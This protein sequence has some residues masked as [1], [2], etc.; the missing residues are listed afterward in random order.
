M[1]ELS[2]HL[3]EH[4][5]TDPSTLLKT[6]IDYPGEVFSE[7]PNR[8]TKRITI[9]DK[10]YFV[11]IHTGVGWIEIFKNLFQGK[12]PILGAKSEY[13]A[14]ARCHEKKIP[15]M[16]VAG[17]GCFGKNPAKQRSFL[18]TE[19]LTFTES[20]ENFCKLWRNA[21]PSFAFKQR[22]IISLAH[23]LKQF[24][25]SGMNHRDCYLCHFRIAVDDLRHPE[26]EGLIS[27][28]VMDLH[29]AQIRKHVPFRWQVKDLGS[30]LFSA[31]HLK[32][33]QR[34]LL[35]FIRHYNTSMSLKDSL[36]SQKNL[37]Q[38]VTDRCH[39]L[40]KKHGEK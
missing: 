23:T 3:Q 30:L 2:K 38:A 13:L 27:L 10:L 33:T 7:A 28:Y 1:I 35:R 20:L 39:Q 14:I 17:F 16:T 5:P 18:I 21:K 37:W 34:D 29:R 11:K 12:L 32:L 36:E 31:S 22:L 19:A 25:E 6:L 24:H 15:T 4:L 8:V 26:R 9:G 40:L